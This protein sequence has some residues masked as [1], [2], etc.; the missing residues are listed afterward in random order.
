ML[1]MGHED[2]ERLRSDWT[3]AARLQTQQASAAVSSEELDHFGRLQLEQVI[4]VCRTAVS[5]SDS[6]V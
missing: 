4:Q 1:D 2:P 5:L 6:G 3:I